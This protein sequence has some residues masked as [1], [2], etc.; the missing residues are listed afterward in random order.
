MSTDHDPLFRFHRWRANP[1]ILEIEEHK[2]VPFVPRSHPF[3]ELLIGTVR[4][5]YLDRVLVWNG[6]DLQ[7]KLERFAVFYDQR[8]VHAAL[9]GRTPAECSGV[10]A[11]PPA[12]LRHFGWRS[13]CTGLFQTP[14]AA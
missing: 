9:G 1:R 14:I 8:R 10:S 12:D 5:E 7:R 4:R 13:D 6:L 11:S 3:V 2:S